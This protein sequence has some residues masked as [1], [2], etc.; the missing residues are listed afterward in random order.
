MHSFV[1]AVDRVDPSET[2]V[3]DEQRQQMAEEA[4]LKDKCQ[5]QDE[6]DP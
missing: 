1:Q 5:Y 3:G 6:V 2:E 4:Y